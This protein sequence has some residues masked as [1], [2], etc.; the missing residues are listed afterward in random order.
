MKHYK[1][2]GF[3]MMLMLLAFVSFTGA[4]AAESLAIKE[5]ATPTNQFII[6]NTV[7]PETIE[8]YEGETVEWRNLQRPKKPIALVSDDGVWEDQ[9]VYYGKLFSYTFEEPGTYEF[10]DANNQYITGTVIVK[11]GTAPLIEEENN[12]ATT[13]V[14]EKRERSFALNMNDGNIDYATAT[15]TIKTA[16]TATSIV[17]EGNEKPDAEAE[18]TEKR[19]VTAQR[20]LTAENQFL[21]VNT[22]TPRV[23]EIEKGETIEWRNLQRPK[24]PIALV[25]DDGM[26]EDQTIY[27]GKVFSYT[28]EESGTYEF[29]DANNQYITGTVIVK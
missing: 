2:T 8:I 16:V 28:F 17:A 21:I 24:N 20:S 29:A 27:Y 12:Q 1:I 25:S 7:T 13:T 14:N 23:I 4:A 10:A 19:T 18:D 9:I 5:P 22:I 11:E 15:T 3:F 6:I 26:W